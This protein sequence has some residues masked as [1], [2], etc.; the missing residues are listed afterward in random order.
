MIVIEKRG[1]KEMYYFGIW[2]F[3]QRCCVLSWEVKFSWTIEEDTYIFR[4]DCWEGFENND[5]LAWYLDI[6]F[7]NTILDQLHPIKSYWSWLM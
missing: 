4:H 5:A 7:F 1:K 6:L 2:I 3:L